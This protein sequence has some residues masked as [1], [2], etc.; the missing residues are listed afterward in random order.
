MLVFSLAENEG[1]V[2]G[3]DI[4]VRVLEVREDTVEIAIEHTESG[5]DE[6]AGAEQVGCEPGSV[7]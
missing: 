7:A 1:V 4:V 6:D 3:D 5:C 2:V